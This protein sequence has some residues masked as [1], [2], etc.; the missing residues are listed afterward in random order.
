MSGRMRGGRVPAFR[1]SGVARRLWPPSDGTV[2]W[3]GRGRG[4]ARQ[5]WYNQTPGQR[6]G[7]VFGLEYAGRKVLMRGA[8][9]EVISILPIQKG[10]VC[11]NWQ[12]IS[13]EEG[14]D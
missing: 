14:D 11:G 6:G 2:G 13:V 10:F 9:S 3:K 1:W 5:I 8:N 4:P 12:K 7:L